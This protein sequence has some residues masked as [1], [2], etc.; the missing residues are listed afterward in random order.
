MSIS[1]SLRV[2]QQRATSNISDDDDAA[3][4]DDK[5]H[6][7]CTNT[8]ANYDFET[9]FKQDSGATMLMSSWFMPMLT[10]AHKLINEPE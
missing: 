4:P 1:Q 3:P 9:H 6:R 2:S 10:G 8:V 5:L 7:T